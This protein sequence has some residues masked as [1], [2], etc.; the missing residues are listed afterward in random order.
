MHRNRWVAVFF[1]F[2]GTGTYLSDGSV[3]I[4]FIMSYKI[5]GNIWYNIEMET[6]YENL[7]GF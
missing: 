7:R 6:G 3:L 4:L 1:I 5:E 2:Y